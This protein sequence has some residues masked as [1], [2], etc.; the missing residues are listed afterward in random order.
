MLNPSVN[1][2]HLSVLKLK[3]SEDTVV[4]FSSVTPRI[5]Y[6]TYLPNLNA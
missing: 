1:V 2:L 3:Q 5:C 6:A 4:F